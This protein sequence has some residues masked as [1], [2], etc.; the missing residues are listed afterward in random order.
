M[1][2]EPAWDQ[3]GYPDDDE[4]RAPSSPGVPCQ[5]PGCTRL[6]WPEPPYYQPFCFEHIRADND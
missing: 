6:Q 1:I 3:E 5:H 2:R 4:D